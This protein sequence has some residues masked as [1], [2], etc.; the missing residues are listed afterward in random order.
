MALAVA[1]GVL[2]TQER[3]SCPAVWSVPALLL[4]VLFPDRTIALLALFP[5]LYWPA[6]VSRDGALFPVSGSLLAV[7][8]LWH[9]IVLDPLTCVVGIGGLTVVLLARAVLT[10]R[11]PG[12]LGLLR[13]PLL[14]TLIVVA[15]VQGLATTARV[16]T[17][18][19]LLDLVLLALSVPAARLVPLLMCLRLPFPPF[20]GFIVLWLGIHAALGLSAGMDGWSVVGVLVALLIGVLSLTDVLTVGR[21]PGQ[22]EFPVQPGGAVLALAGSVLLL[23]VV[24]FGCVSPVLN[25]MGGDW[26][27]PVWSVGGGDGAHL[28]LM[29]VMMLM[30]LFWLVLVRP[31]RV[32]NGLVEGAAALLP[33][34]DRLAGAENGLFEET[35]SLSWA[36]RRLIVGG[37]AR[38][39]ALAG[40]RS[41]RVPDMRQSAMGLW[42]LL[43]GL[44][45][46]MLGLMS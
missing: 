8:M 41:V 46:A 19:M 17:E 25:F 18:A 30:G 5:V 11:V 33:A 40:L 26:V 28:R 21:R 39:R 12:D 24:V 20:P 22:G 16:A 37:K 3:E 6:L 38:L 42:L 36:V 29:A 7:A 43:L 23:P 34:L 44:V 31:W 14:M 2:L 27:W 13:P 9:A 45:L 15:E 4:S 10:A 1:L 35:P 32:R